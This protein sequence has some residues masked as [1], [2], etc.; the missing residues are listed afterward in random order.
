MAYNASNEERKTLVEIEKNSRGEYVI[1]SLITNKSN[2]NQSLDIRQYY[3]NDEDQ[4]LPTSKGIRLSSEMALELVKGLID[5]LEE[6]EAYDLYEELA[7][8]F[9]DKEEDVEEIED[10]DE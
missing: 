5:S 8:R 10:E 9:M 6:D 4:V 2:G 1:A 3:T 7:N